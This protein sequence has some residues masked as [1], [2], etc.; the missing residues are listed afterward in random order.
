MKSFRKSLMGLLIA[1]AGLSLSLALIACAGG[2]AGRRAYQFQP[3]AFIGT[4]Q[5]YNG[6]LTVETVFSE[7]R[8]ESVTVIDHMETPNF[9][10]IPI[11]RIPFE[12]VQYQS[13]AVDRVAGATVTSVA[14]VAAVMDTVD[15]AV[16]GNPGA[17]FAPRPARRQNPPATLQTQILVV[18]SGMAGLSAAL[19]AAYHG[20]D[21]LLI[22]K[23][24]LIGGT[25]STSGGI[26]HGSNNSIQRAAGYTADTPEIH[27]E[28]LLSLAGGIELNETFLE[29]AARSSGPSIDW[30]RSMGVIFNPTPNHSFYRFTSARALQTAGGAH[31]LMSSI[32][33][34][35]TTPM[36][37]FARA[38]GIEIMTETRAVSLIMD[39]NRVVGANAVDRTG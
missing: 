36:A 22:E 29:F 39:G 24:G 34:E 27:L 2:G 30:L 14:I 21:V 37:R 5:G 23:L 13:L 28:F 31:L 32:G 10:L 6:I 11:Q 20:A 25:T 16:S 19:E 18:G 17:L 12:I 33:H 9:A 4:A 1:L 3:G 7:R 8:I 26:I 38:R 15:Q 35:F